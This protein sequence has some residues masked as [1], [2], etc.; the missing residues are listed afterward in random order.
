MIQIETIKE[1]KEQSYTT[2]QYLISAI[3]MVVLGGIIFSNPSSVIKFI[4]YVLAVL[5]IGYGCFRIYSYTKLNNKNDDLKYMLL[6]SGI[7]FILIGILLIVFSNAIE[8][9]I[10]IT[11]GILINIGGSDPDKRFELKV[12]I[13]FRVGAKLDLIA[14]GG[15]YGG[16]AKV[17]G[18]IE[19]T[20]FDANVGLRL[21]VYILD[22]FHEIYIN[23]SINAIKIRGYA[24]TEIDIYIYKSKLVLFEK[25]F[26]LKVPLLN[27]YYYLKVDFWGQVLESEKD[28]KTISDYMR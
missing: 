16:I 4:S 14:E 28:S 17:V 10:R 11:L 18:G 13:E 12:H 19:G 2:K 22:G 6:A 24:E 21:Y 1:T 5:S 27:M 3:I 23:L 26:G 15:L 8:V 25:E 9:I 20:L 7:I